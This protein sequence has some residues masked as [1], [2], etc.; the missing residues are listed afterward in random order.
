[1][2]LTVVHP[3]CLDR[4]KGY[5]GFWVYADD[6]QHGY[7]VAA[8]RLTPL[9]RLVP[10][11]EF[12]EHV[13][14]VRRSFVEW[15]DSSLADAPAEVWL[16]TPLSKNPLNDNFFLHV[17]WLTAIGHAIKQ[18]R[19]NILVVTSSLG[20]SIALQGICRKREVNYRQ[21]GR[22]RV[23]ASH[24]AGALRH[25]AGF[26]ASA[27]KLLFRIF[28]ARLILGASYV[29]RLKDTGILMDTYLFDADLSQDGQFTDRYFPGLVEWYGKQGF[30]VAI[31]PYIYQVP[32]SRLPS[33]Y[34]RMR[35][36][37]TLFVPVELFVTISDFLLAMWRC[38]RATTANT[39]DKVRPFLGVEAHAL[40]KYN[41]TGSALR[42][43]IPHILMLVPNR[44][45]AKGVRPSWFVDWYENQPIDKANFIG[46]SRANISCRV[47]AARQYPPH[48]NVLSLFSTNGE[49]AAG[50]APKD[51]LICGKALASNFS[52][53]DT[54]GN[55]RVVPALRY[56]HL[57]RETPQHAS[58][59]CLV[60]LLPYSIE[61]SIGILDCI[62]PAWEAVCRKFDEI[63]I[64]PHHTMRAE[65]IRSRIAAELL[66]FETAVSTTL[67]WVDE[68]M[69][70]LLAEARIVVS[71]QS[72]TLLEAVCRGVPAISIGRPAGIPMNPL[73]GIDQRLWRLVYDSE[74][75]SHVVAQWSP[76]HP[77]PRAERI[78]LGREIRDVYFE[79]RSESAMRGF[80]PDSFNQ[81]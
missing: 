45:A 15:V 35:Q 5:K 71:A 9:Q 7:R 55:Y 70:T 13:S 36:S 54:I 25:L 44:I 73:E 27:L 20:L 34:W 62:L 30:T 39:S 61:D 33:L 16:T 50:A 29:T 22:S 58:R 81:D 69:E 24:M 32:I 75:F 6:D 67:V 43:L 79:P 1:M 59:N 57:H 78:A 18:R 12:G 74:Q 17:C 47:V 38:L 37:S 2:E 65:N 41:R 8:D 10:P 76:D 42:G 68:P 14:T 52:I 26:C 53:Y 21:I 11:E 51:N 80:I 77:L 60:I 49:V 48:P 64:K 40:V 23:F 72:G 28:L 19:G 3:A 46:F 66:D 31:Y 63:K 56:A 4:C